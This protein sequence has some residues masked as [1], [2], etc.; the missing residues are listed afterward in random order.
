M[1][2]LEMF[3][4]VLI[5]ANKIIDALNQGRKQKDIYYAHAIHKVGELYL[6]SAICSVTDFLFNVLNKKGEPHQGYSACWRVWPIVSKELN[7]KNT[8][9]NSDNIVYIGRG[10][11][12]KNNA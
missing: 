8:D 2:Q 5:G 9:L 4:D 10:L 7:I 12:G 11:N 3:D 1:S 6:L